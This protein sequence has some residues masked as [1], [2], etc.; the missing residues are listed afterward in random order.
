M[1]P[2]SMLRI[3]TTLAMAPLALALLGQPSTADPSA[4]GS[5]DESPAGLR[6][7]GRVL[8]VSDLGT[9][10]APKVAWAERID[11]KRVTIHGTGGDTPAPGD[12]LGFAP[13]GSGYVIQGSGDQRGAAVRWIGSDGTPGA[14]T[15]HTGYGLAVS[16]KGQ[17][18][19]FTGSRGRV[20]V[21]DSE[22]DRVLRMPS[23]P[24]R[25]KHTPVVVG[26]EDC[27]EGPTSDGCGVWV[28]STR[29]SRSWVTS[30][31][32]IV[33]RAPFLSTS[34]GRDRWMGGIT[35][36]SDFGSC[37]VMRRGMRRAWDTCRNRFSAISPDRR[38]VLGL[39]AYG[40]GF[41]PT[42]LDV[43]DLRTGER[44]RSWKGSRDGDS[45]TYFD[46]M[47]EDSEHLLVV[48]YQAGKWAIVRLGMDGSREYAVAPRRGS[49]EHFRFWLPT[50]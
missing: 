8:D 37:S 35:K 1:R 49:M 40:D 25:G 12:L 19:A 4:P 30:S 5:R 27:Q 44:V 29:G 18:V 32:G 28:N 45:A 36:I 48:T 43:L 21:I 46:E 20:W 7:P 16:P 15:W 17:A 22:G 33:D 31:H 2:R 3:L 47:W 39:P 50:S 24:G 34:T 42:R 6:G 10:A 9:G 11:R 38:H 26:G 14:R 23:V 41:G 13:M